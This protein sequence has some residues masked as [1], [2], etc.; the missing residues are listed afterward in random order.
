MVVAHRTAHREEVRTSRVA[1]QLLWVVVQ[2]G[3]VASVAGATC[4]TASNACSHVAV[5][6]TGTLNEHF[7]GTWQQE[8]RSVGRRQHNEG[9]SIAYPSSTQTAICR[10]IT[11]WIDALILNF[12]EAA[13]TLHLAGTGYAASL[14]VCRRG[15]LRQDTEACSQS[16]VLGSFICGYSPCCRTSRSC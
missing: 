9:C 2:C 13:V 15:T 12:T 10:I 14:R 4:V 11:Y 8:F 3:I 16:G 6:A 1:E 5:R 7:S